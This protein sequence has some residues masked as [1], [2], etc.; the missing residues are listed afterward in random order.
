MYCVKSLSLLALVLAAAL[1]ALPALAQDQEQEQDW[2]M[3]RDPDKQTVVAY[4]PL[5]TGL[6]IGVRC[7]K[8]AFGAVIAGLPEAPRGQQTRSLTMTFG[9]RPAQASRWNVT[10]NRTVAIA[11]YPASFARNLRDG[12]RLQIT[13]PG[14]GGGGRDLRHDLTLPP[15]QAA[16]DE[17]LAA[18]GKP[19]ED[20]RDALLPEIGEGGL[21][22]GVTWTRRPSVSWPM[23][24]RYLEG[25]AVV[26]CMV[27]PDGGL[28][29]CEV[30]S[31]HPADGVFGQAVL[32]A[33]A[34]ARI[35]SPNET[36]GAFASRRI[37]FRVNFSAR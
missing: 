1:P 37:G 8:N 9:D 23:N 36:P 4:I 2:E 14:G 5:T 27:T 10:T 3:M 21:P 22:A 20:P 16:I 17:V 25:Y 32:R 18:C 7:T 35:G 15:S 12:G 34:R 11:D 30:E 29:L 24:S 31:E 33:A 28:N 6:S 26:T 13:V 19:T